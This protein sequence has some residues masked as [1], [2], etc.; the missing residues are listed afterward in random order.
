MNNNLRLLY[1]RYK[2]TTYFSLAIIAVVFSA[3]ILLFFKV[4]VPQ[5]QNWFSIS[6]EAARTR[7]RIVNIEKNIS[8]MNTLDKRVLNDQ[9]EVAT[10]A[11]PLEKNFGPIINALSD[12]AI[13]S[14]VALDDFSFQVGDVS[15]TSGKL[16]LYGQKGL[17]ALTV[18][19]GVTGTA[20]QIHAFLKETQ[21]KLPIS[22]ATVVD[23]DEFSTN[24]TLQFYQKQFPRIVFKD[25]ELI[26][27]LSAKN[28]TLLDELR[29]WQPVVV[30]EVKV[31]TESAG[32]APLF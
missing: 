8:F 32:S 5:L 29:G 25:D 9:L 26:V 15:S 31:G 28:I 30:S 7:E 6:Q 4:I 20:T 14:G 19:V 23:G 12:A 17:S 16:N 2:G 22:E 21:E 24:I 1:Y 11:I 13:S 18:N 10:S 27:P 3:C